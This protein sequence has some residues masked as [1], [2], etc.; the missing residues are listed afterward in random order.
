MITKHFNLSAV[1]VAVCNVSS[2]PAIAHPSNDID[3]QSFKMRQADT[4]II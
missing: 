4:I 2:A 3:A 1:S